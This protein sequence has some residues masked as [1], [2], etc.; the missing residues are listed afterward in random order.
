MD[1]N[2]IVFSYFLAASLFYNEAVLWRG[3]YFPRCLLLFNKAVFPGCAAGH[4]SRVGLHGDSG[5]MERM[6]PLFITYEKLVFQPTARMLW[7]ILLKGSFTCRGAG[8]LTGLPEGLEEAAERH[9][10][11]LYQE[12]LELRSERIEQE[13]RKGE[14]AFKLR[15][16]ALERVGLKNVREYHRK[17]LNQ[18]YE[19]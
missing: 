11:N 12:M 19:Q 2:N 17:Q 1:K 6:L 18:E 15:T 3:R 9:G 4:S 5:V 10:Y 16:S 13:R 7:D 14:L 8:R